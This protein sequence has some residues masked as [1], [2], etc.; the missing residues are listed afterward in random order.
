MRYP[1]LSIIVPIY[2]VENYLE[3][4]LN[5]L[6]N[7]QYNNFEVIMVND[8]S[9]DNSEEIMHKFSN[10][11]DNFYAFTKEN[12]GL[13]QARN[14]GVKYATGEYIAFVDSD[15][16]IVEGSYKLMM[17]TILKTDSDFII[18]NVVRFNSTKEYPSVLHKKVF[19]ETKLKT[20]IY[21]SPELLYDT[22]AW[23]KIYKMS[24]WKKHNFKFPEGM[25]YEDIPVTQPAHFLANSVDVLPNIIY[26]WR[27]RDFGD[28]SITQKRTEISN[29][30]DRIKAVTM[31][32]NFF[33]KENKNIPHHIVVEKDYKVLSIDLLVY[34]NQLPNANDEYIKTYLDLVSNY[35]KSVSKE[36]L[37]R[38]KVIDKMKYYFVLQKDKEKVLELIKFQKNQL[39][40][41][42]PVYENGQYVF[43]YPYSELVPNEY[44]TAEAELIPTTKI[45]K[46]EWQGK[47]L[48]LKGYAYI[49]KIDLKSKSSSSIEVFLID[50][51]GNHIL[52][53]NKITRTKRTDI[54]MKYG[55]PNSK[56]IP[57]KRAF[58]Y[59]WSGF[60]IE[61]DFEDENYKT[62]FED[63]YYLK[64]NISVEGLNKDILLGQPSPGLKTKPNYRIIRDKIIYPKYNA[65]WD[66][67]F[68]VRK[69]T[70][71]VNNIHP[72]QNGLKIEGKTN[73]Q[74][75]DELKFLLINYDLNKKYTI[76]LT[77]KEKRSRAEYQYFETFID[78]SLLSET[79]NRGNWYGHILNGEDKNNLTLEINNKYK[80]IHAINNSIIVDHSPAANLL[81]TV[82]DFEPR[83]SN[84]DVTTQNVSIKI[85]LAK[86]FYEKNNLSPDQ[87]NLLFINKNKTDNQ[88][89]IQTSSIIEEGNYIFLKFNFPL[90]QNK[91]QPFFS[92]GHWKCHIAIYNNGNI[93]TKP[94]R[95]FAEGDKRIYKIVKDIKFVF[96]KGKTSRNM[97]LSVA[98]EW[99]KIERGPRRQEVIRKVI[100]P[101]M[102]LLPMKRKTIVFESYWGKGFDDNPRAL[103]EYIINNHPEYET[104]WFLKNQYTNV[105]GDAKRVRINS[106]KYYYY[107]ARAKYFV[108]NVN[109][110]DF[111]NK[112]KN[113]IEIQTMHG[114]PLKTLGLDNPLEVPTER[115][116]NN[117]LRRCSRW[118]YLTVPSDYVASI[119]KR[120]YQFNKTIL[121]TGYP[122]NDKLFKNNNITYIS[123]IKEKLNLPTNKKIILYAPTWR[124]KG[125]YQLQMDLDSMKDEL[126][127]DYIVLIKL[128]HFMK[129]GFSLDKYQGFAFDLSWYDQISDLYLITDILITDYSSVMFDFSLLEK[130]MIFFTYDYEKYKNQLRG[131]YLDFKEEAPGPLV[132]DTGEIIKEIKDIENFYKKYGKRYSIF[133]KK[134]C[135][136]DEGNACEKI[137][138]IIFKSPK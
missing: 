96:L 22:T 129:K 85:R 116:R 138:N 87:S 94:I 122:R 20:N 103:Y 99:K 111:Y 40:F 112:R 49:N 53:I 19:S 51:N 128:H 119:A 27:A 127:N 109:F 70:S 11:Y 132:Y 55:I 118:D 43:K 1:K 84:I 41:S 102:R 57:L 76:P 35:L 48:L 17:E 108:N 126:G 92:T 46:L 125:T 6:L 91:E 135:Q 98:P 131:M 72:V 52:P 7:Q 86:Q 82:T 13:G 10:K 80:E 77:F 28:Q 38:L 133:K 73:E 32:D 75:I 121:N 5:S 4:C 137:F 3:D 107:L 33:K 56:L 9:T 24:F 120:A 74:P 63:D 54:T 101:L 110:P 25:L 123:K 14:F 114:T 34:L 45:E 37:L 15:D 115:Q 105:I 21:K 106:L 100:Y 47:R 50:K 65:S 83:V 18:G 78:Y 16:I 58:N 67:K 71:M 134:F 2:N 79:S 26:K 8:G 130:P 36:A 31:V 124:I 81:L 29:L 93:I 88:L 113:A 89:N 42:K 66:L 69:L 60:I 68:E 97:Y 95:F 104:V 117:L 23:N 90:F 12:G 61:I 39:K 136:Y 62:I 59:N 30:V 44:K 64:L